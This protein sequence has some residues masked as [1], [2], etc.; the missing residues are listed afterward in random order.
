[1]SIVVN[2]QLFISRLTSNVCQNLDVF[3]GGAE[4]IHFSS[5]LQ[6]KFGVAW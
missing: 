5:E 2:L 3:A 4:L 6:P 1:M